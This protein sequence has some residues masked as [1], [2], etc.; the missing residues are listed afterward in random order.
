M[1]GVLLRR[2][3][4]CDKALC[5][6]LAERSPDFADDI[7]LHNHDPLLSPNTAVEPARRLVCRRQ[8]ETAAA[9]IGLE[10]G[11]EL[12]RGFDMR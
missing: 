7:P 6:F 5:R 4:Q 8:R 9:P 11:G 1:R 3:V 12:D 2:A 10:C